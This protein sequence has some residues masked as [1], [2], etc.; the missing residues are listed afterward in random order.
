MKIGQYRAKWMRLHRNYERRALKILMATFRKWIKRIDFD[1]INLTNYKT[2]VDRSSN[3]IEMFDTYREIYKQIGLAHGKRV[4]KSINQEL[5]NFDPVSFETIYI[6]RIAEY[7]QK[8]GIN[9][10]TTVEKTYFKDIIKLFETRLAEGKTII[11]TSKEIKELVNKKN[12]YKWQALRIARTETTASANFS[13]IQS[14][15]ITQ[16]QMEKIWISALDERTRTAHREENR[17]R[18]GEKDT[19]NVGGEQLLYPGDP[20]GSAGNVINCRCTVSI[21]PKRDKNGSLVPKKPG[22]SIGNTTAPPKIP[23]APKPIKP[24]PIVENLTSD[25]S[26]VPV[27][28]ALEFKVRM[29]KLGINDVTTR[30][31]K[32][33]ELNA[34]L[35]VFENEAK[36]SSLSIKKFD[37]NN[38][39]KRA[40]AFYRPSENSITVNIN[41]MR[42]F[43]YKDVESY[44]VKLK[45]SKDLLKK[46][47][48][49]YL[50]KPQYNQTQVRKNY[51]SIKRQISNIEDKIKQGEN[52]LFWSTSSMGK[53]PIEAMQRTL[54]H[55][56]GHGRHYKKLNLT[57]NFNFN[58]NNSISDYGKTNF[59][60]YFTEWYTY[61]RYNGDS[62]IPDDLLTLFK[63]I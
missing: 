29:G 35:S 25:S 7:L 47:E 4:G 34:F 24:K 28:N 48:D 37:I 8:N 12:F 63:Q 11:E 53:T 41:L 1:A 54:V 40:R 36:F 56:I 17:T 13:A 14:A 60:E 58:R 61:W 27:K 38:R 9:R 52:P 46:Y 57:R 10:I 18:V 44:H 59:K 16:F 20:N 45:Q 49:L 26:F 32:T 2:I 62:K 33:E 6:S 3:P 19:F 42:K 23:V 30:G 43:I 55:E 50:G 31:L 39:K 15:N 5:K 21:V 51:R 22:S